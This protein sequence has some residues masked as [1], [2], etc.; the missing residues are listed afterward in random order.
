MMH[1]NAPSMFMRAVTWAL[2]PLQDNELSLSR[3]NEKAGKQPNCE[4]NENLQLNYRMT[5]S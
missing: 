4:I 3:S 2:D 5:S 1:S